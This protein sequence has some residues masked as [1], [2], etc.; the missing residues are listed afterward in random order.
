MKKTNYLLGS[1]FALLVCILPASAQAPDELQ[2]FQQAA[3]DHSILYRGKQADRYNYLANG[4]PYWSDATFRLGD[5]LCEGKLYR[6]VPINID[7][8]KQ[9]VLV[10]LSASMLAVSL[11]PEQVP[12]FTIGDRRFIGTGPGGALPEGFYEIIGSGPELIYKHIDKQL[13]SSTTNM[14]GDPIG[15]Y[16]ENYRSNVTRYFAH[17][18][19]YYFRDAAGVISRFKGR[20]ALIRKFPGRKKEIRQ[21]LRA[22]R[23]D[24][25]GVSFDTFCAAV[26]STASSR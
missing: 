20:N 17:K 8:R 15:Y 6:D 9:R 2:A 10:Q 26:L 22:A 14:N 25:P 13:S 3:G 11:T 1:L 23:L 24:E 5:L 12:S 21:A 18:A 7:A 4:N 19:T 16:D